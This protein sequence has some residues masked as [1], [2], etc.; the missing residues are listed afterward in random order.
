M[1]AIGDVVHLLRRTEFVARPERVAALEPLTYE[2]A[3]DDVL[4]VPTEVVPIPPEL[5]VHDGDNSYAQYQGAVHWWFERMVRTSPRPVQEKMALFWHGHFCTSYEKVFDMGALMAQ[6]QLFRTEAL[7]NVRR[8]AQAMAIQPAM[9]RYLDNDQNTKRSPNQNF[10]RELLELFLLGVGNYTEADVE[11]ATA[12]WTGH[13][14]DPSTGQY[15]FR[16]DRHDT[17][18]KTFLGRTGAW[19]GPDIIDIVLGPDAVVAVGPN[20][21]LPTRVVAARFLSAKLWRHLASEHPSPATVHQ[22]GDVLVAHDFEIRPW[23]RALLTHPD[24][25]TDAVRTGLVRTPT[26]LIAHLLYHS[27]VLA[28]DA[29]PEWY[30]EGMGQELFRPPNVSGWRV[31]GYWINTAALA[32]RASFAD[33]IRWILLGTRS[34]GGP[35][36]LRSGSW[37]YAALDALT[38]AEL[39][40]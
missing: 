16:A 38:G 19:D 18:T 20:A 35:L 25:R 27:G 24:F 12:A 5:A 31:N 15:L 10:A 6:N 14:L 26:E 39:V 3:V 23:L 36:T 8:L 37:T 40:D 30:A 9:L 32:A 29:H 21:G 1:A 4:D 17:G 2:Q 11:A 28:A 13:Q 34:A 7:G 33:R 22:L